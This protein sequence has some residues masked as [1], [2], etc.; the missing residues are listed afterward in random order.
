MALHM[1]P[2]VIFVHGAWHSPAHFQAVRDLFEADGFPTKCP[3]QPSSG[4]APTVTLYDDAH[5]V[6]SVTEKSVKSEGRDVISAMHSY[7]GMV[8]TQATN[9]SF[10]KASR[11]GQGLQG[12]VIRLLYI[13]AFLLPLGDSLGSA[14]GG[15]LPP[16]ITVHVCPSGRS[17][18]NILAL[19]ADTSRPQGGRHL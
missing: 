11:E 7:G 3:T 15:K 4:G 8:G 1:K 16:F 13:C 6:R 10:G 18:L 12:G 19:S 17:T 2:T 5:C 9:E 14:F